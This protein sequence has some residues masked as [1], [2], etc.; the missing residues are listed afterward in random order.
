MPHEADEGTEQAQHPLCA[1]GQ[2][3][4]WQDQVIQE[5]SPSRVEREFQGLA[6]DPGAADDLLAFRFAARRLDERPDLVE[7][8]KVAARLVQEAGNGGTSPGE[9]DQVE[10]YTAI[11]LRCDPAA[12][13]VEGFRPAAL[14]WGLV[15]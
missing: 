14:L 5:A 6:D 13:A 7:A 2:P 12:P 15:V 8:A 10:R 9:W 3:L 4:R 11:L 1:R